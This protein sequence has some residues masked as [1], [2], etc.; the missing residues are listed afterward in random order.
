MNSPRM[1]VPAA[2]RSP[3]GALVPTIDREIWLPRRPVTADHTVSAPH[4]LLASFAQRVKLALYPEAGT[5][6]CP[7]REQCGHALRSLPDEAY[8][9]HRA[10]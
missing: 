5:Q 3:F 7:V 4:A 6:R 10:R 1:S 9:A 2:A 8:V